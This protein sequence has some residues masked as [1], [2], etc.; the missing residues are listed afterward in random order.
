MF[1]AVEKWEIEKTNQFLRRKFDIFIILEFY[2]ENSIFIDFIG[3][4]R[5][6]GVALFAYFCREFRKIIVIYS[7]ECFH[8]LMVQCCRSSIR[9]WPGNVGG[10]VFAGAEAQPQPQITGVCK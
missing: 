8:G 9:L 7:F 2:H 10:V 5:H 3:S 1:S 6:P 4:V